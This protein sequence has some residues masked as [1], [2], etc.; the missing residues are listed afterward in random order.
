VP[1]LLDGVI[2]LL[3]HNLVQRQ[4]QPDGE[5]RLLMLETMRAFGLERLVAAGEA[6]STRRRHAEHFLALAEAAADRLQG[7]DRALWLDRIELELDN[8]RAALTWATE[9]GDRTLALR[10]AGALGQTWLNRGRVDEG[11]DWLAQALAGDD[12]AG[13][14]AP[15]ARGVCL[16]WL[17]LIE[18]SRGDPARAERH[19]REALALFRE[20][21]DRRLIVRG[22]VGLGM[23][24]GDR[25]DDDD[26]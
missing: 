6:E 9:G 12:P 8:L 13:S 25:S 17:G 19:L 10:L 11:A 22:L 2:A 4:D 15:R 14:V 5:P 26:E 16:R 20:V 24:A 18:R 3:D 1:P 21:G 7:P 23:L